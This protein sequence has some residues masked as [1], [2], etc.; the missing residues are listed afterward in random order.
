MA[1]ETPPFLLLAHNAHASE[2]GTNVIVG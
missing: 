2:A 1:R